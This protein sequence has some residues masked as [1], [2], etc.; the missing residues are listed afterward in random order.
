MEPIPIA[1]I[2]LSCRFAGDATDPEKLWKLCAEG[3]TAW[4]EIPASKFNLKGCY[5]P[6]GERSETTNVTG[7]HFLKEDIA[8]FDAAFF[9]FPADLASVCQHG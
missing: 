5:H 8:A 7:G 6:N 4:S 3:G 2:G 9:G 1:I